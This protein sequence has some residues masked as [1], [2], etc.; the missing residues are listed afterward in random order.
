MGSA[1]FWRF[2]VSKCFQLTK[3]WTECNEIRLVNGLVDSWQRSWSQSGYQLWISHGF[4]R[5]LSVKRDIWT[6]EVQKILMKVVGQ[7]SKKTINIW[8]WRDSYSPLRDRDWGGE[9]SRTASRRWSSQTLVDARSS[10]TMT[11]ELQAVPPGS[12]G[13][14][15]LY[16]YMALSHTASLLRSMC[17]VT[18]EEVRLK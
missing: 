9:A 3:L 5:I 11:P 1:A 7:T 2:V 10:K 12:T 17:W 13:Q 14:C 4:P 16:I 6:N 15:Q 18:V 8:E